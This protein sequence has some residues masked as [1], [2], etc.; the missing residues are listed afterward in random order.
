VIQLLGPCLC[1]AVPADDAPDASKQ[2]TL[3]LA[4]AQQRRIAAALRQ[5]GEAQS[6]SSSIPTPSATRVT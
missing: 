6:G 4:R 1:Q 3:A 2:R 5:V